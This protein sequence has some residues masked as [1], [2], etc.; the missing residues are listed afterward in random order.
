MKL[1]S[2]IPSILDN[3]IFVMSRDAGKSP[4]FLEGDMQNGQKRTEKDGDELTGKH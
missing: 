2:L 1:N 3:N 4:A